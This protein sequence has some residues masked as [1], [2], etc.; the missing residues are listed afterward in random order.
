MCVEKHA[1]TRDRAGTSLYSQKLSHLQEGNVSLGKQGQ[2]GGG[3]SQ[4][5]EAYYR[6]SRAFEVGNL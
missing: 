6:N 3:R 2:P 5:E 4:R 1:D